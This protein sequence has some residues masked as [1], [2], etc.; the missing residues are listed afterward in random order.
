[1]LQPACFRQKIRGGERSVKIKV[2][3]VLVALVTVLVAG[4]SPAQ[5]PATQEQEPPVEA[6][7]LTPLSPEVTVTVGAKEVVSDA[8]LN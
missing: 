8:G 4:C 6:D 7:V 3:L 1:M 5:P 2:W